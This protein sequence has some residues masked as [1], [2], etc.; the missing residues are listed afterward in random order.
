MD[1]L[2]DKEAQILIKMLT[3]DCQNSSNYLLK[4]N[5]KTTL[6]RRATKMIQGLG[7]M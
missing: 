5:S 3:R 7:S 6:Q 2:Q 4:D 1:F